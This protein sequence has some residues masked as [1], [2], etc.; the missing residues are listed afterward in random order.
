MK[1]LLNL[2]EILH[3]RVIGQN[4]A[5][6]TVSKAIRRSRLGIQNPS[7]PIGSFLFCGPTG[8]GKTELSK[9]LTEAIFGSEKE[10]IRFDMSEFMERF[11]VTRLIGSPPGYVGYEEG[12]QLTDS[13]RKK[14]Y[15]LI[16]FDE[17]EKAHIEVL[18]IL[19]QILE[20]GRLTDSQKRLVFFENTIIIMTSNAAAKEIQLSLEELEI[21]TQKISEKSKEVSSNEKI[22]LTKN[23]KSEKKH[24]NQFS[25]IPR[26][27]KIELL[28]ISIK[29]N[30]TVDIKENLRKNFSDSYLGKNYFN[31]LYENFP[32][33]DTKNI[34]K[35]ENKEFTLVTKE[36]FSEKQFF[37]KKKLDNRLIG[38][39]DSLAKKSLSQV[40]VKDLV[41]NKL[42]KFFLPEFINRLDDIIV[43]ESL[44]YENVIKIYDVMIE[45]L[46]KRVKTNKI[47]L[48]IDPSVKGKLVSE[49]YSKTFGARPLRRLITKYLEDTLSNVLLNYQGNDLTKISKEGCK[50]RISL[51]ENDI[52][53]GELSF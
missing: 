9:A 15:A 45:K 39:S 52:V 43:F 22:V 47:N 41:M 31:N 36:N 44:T 42:T 34:E 28:P 50:I 53:L 20:D 46:I 40:D 30:F 13:V 17:I 18:N 11:S 51:S 10:M 38:D 2:E 14:P 24:F 3:K 23:L 26:L 37:I 4:E 12:G 48:V 25:I 5:I 6:A 16:L 19:L 49:G 35:N 29:T 7:R 8:V 27:G 21:N 1:R 32:V 33:L